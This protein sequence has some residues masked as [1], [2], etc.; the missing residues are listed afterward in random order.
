MS[1]VYSGAIV[2]KIAHRFYLPV[3]LHRFPP[4]YKS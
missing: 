1:I 3:R 2:K 4:R